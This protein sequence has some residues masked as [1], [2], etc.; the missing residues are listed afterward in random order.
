M[1]KNEQALC[2]TLIRRLENINNTVRSEVTYPE[3]DGSGPPVEV[4][5][6]LGSEKYAIEHTLL[7]PF[8]QSIQMGAEFQAFAGE[9]ITELNGTM[10]TPGIYDLI[11]PLHPTQGRHRRTHPALREAIISW[12]RASAEELHAECPERPQKDRRPYGYEGVRKNAFDGLELTLSRR[13]HWADGGRHEGA[14]LPVRLVSDDIEPLRRA[15]VQ[16]AIDSKFGKLSD[17]R[18][19][20]DTTVLILEFADVA[21]TNHVLIAEALQPLLAGRDDVPDHIF[22][23][24]TT[25]DATWHLFHVLD[26]GNFSIEVDWIEIDTNSS[27]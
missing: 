5:F 4:R 13:L 18:H 21:L 15:R 12:A 10:P 25:G 6:R 9:I 19:L 14:L 23:A 3:I 22:I 26:G 1:R 11:F 7:E 2:E 20:G 8:A 27:L 17:C 24:D 16:Q